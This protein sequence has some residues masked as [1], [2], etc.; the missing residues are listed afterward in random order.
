MT[1]RTRDILRQ[2]L[3]AVFSIVQVL[4]AFAVAIPGL[5]TDVG[6]RAAAW[7]NPAQPAPFA[8]AIWGIIYPASIAYAIYQAQPSQ[9]ENPLLRHIGWYTFAAFLAST[10]WLIAAQLGASVWPLLVL[11]GALLAALLVAVLRVADARE[12]TGA[13]RAFVVFPLGLYAGWATVATVASVAVVVTVS[14]IMTPGLALLLI[15]AAGVIGVYLTYLTRGNGWFALAIAWGLFG[16]VVA[17]PNNLPAAVAAGL[18]GALVLLAV[19]FIRITLF[20]R[21]IAAAGAE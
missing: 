3:N 19:P 1:E 11:I 17:N 6:T 14:G 2:V 15:L 16:I 9:R 8:F 4:P 5:V 21:A 20:T 10:A 12:L 18:M 13:E 7:D